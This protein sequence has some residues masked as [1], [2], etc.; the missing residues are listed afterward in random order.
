MVG[1]VK[2]IYAVL[3]ALVLGVVMSQSVPPY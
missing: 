1:G 3:L 2:A